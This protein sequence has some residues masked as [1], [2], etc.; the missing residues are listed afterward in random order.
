[1][2]DRAF[3]AAVRPSR[4][5]HRQAPAGA[6]RRR[7]AGLLAVVLA[8]VLAV[9][10]A[11]PAR[12]RPAPS[13]PAPAPAAAASATAAP[14][15]RFTFFGLGQAAAG[16]TL[17]Q[18]AAALGQPL[19]AEPVAAAR[20]A[21]GPA[22]KPVA[23]AAAGS[24]CHYR[25]AA[26]H[27]GVR[28]AVAGD[29]ITRVETRDSRYASASGVHVGDSLQRAQQVYGRRLTL[30]PHPYFDKGRLASVVSPDRR[31]ALVMESNDGGRIITLRSGRLPDVGWLEGCS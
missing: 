14:T 7:L 30:A 24:G 1:M 31:F 21:S 26:G 22:L 5:S 8:V 27:P 2:T 17:A 6:A 18:A 12:A 15:D 3:P 19:L 10:T 20:A 9:A 11:A 25:S 16:Q 29:V 23:A 13:R 4:P 28:Y